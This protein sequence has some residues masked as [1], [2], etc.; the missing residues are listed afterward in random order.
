MRCLTDFGGRAQGQRNLA[1]RYLAI[2]GPISC[3]APYSARPRRHAH[4]KQYP[5]LWQSRFAAIEPVAGQKGIAAIVCDGA[6]GVSLHLSRDSGS[7]LAFASKQIKQRLASL[8]R[9][10]L[11]CEPT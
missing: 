2:C 11:G 7:N 10:S 8:I 4:E 6:T 5:L 1:A 3:D 9:V